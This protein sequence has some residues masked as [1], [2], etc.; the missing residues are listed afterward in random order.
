M[1]AYTH[2]LQQT[3][4]ISEAIWRGERGEFK[5]NKMEGERVRGEHT[6]KEKRWE[7]ECEFSRKI[8]TAGYKQVK[9]TAASLAKLVT[10]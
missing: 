3:R 1:H 2:T 9:S 8:T 10:Y 4:K 6:K 5:T 7:P